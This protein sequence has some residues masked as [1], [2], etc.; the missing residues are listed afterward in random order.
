MR[1]TVG[2]TPDRMWTMNWNC[3]SELGGTGLS[4]PFEQ[5]VIRDP[6]YAAPE[7][8]SVIPAA[9][10]YEYGGMIC[11]HAV[12]HRVVEPDAEAVRQTGHW[13][14]PDSPDRHR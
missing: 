5:L 12:V 6:V 4:A 2:T 9:R 10:D 11:G 3:S 14:P 7:Y 1:L 13:A 8:H